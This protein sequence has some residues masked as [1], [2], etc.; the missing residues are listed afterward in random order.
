MTEHAPFPSTSGLRILL[1]RRKARRV[2]QVPR[3]DT[4]PF[5]RPIAASRKSPHN[6]TT[7]IKRT[8]AQGVEGGR[9]ISFPA[10]CPHTETRSHGVRPTR[11]Q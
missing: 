5:R 10:S 4:G 11:T 7:L 8:A 3:G 2:G 1:E 6:L 9:F